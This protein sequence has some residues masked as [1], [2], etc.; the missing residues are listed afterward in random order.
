MSAEEASERAVCFRG[1]TLSLGVSSE[2]E[3]RKERMGLSGFDVET[4]S[5]IDFDC[6]SDDF[7]ETMSPSFFSVVSS[8]CGN[9]ASDSFSSV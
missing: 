1:G 3:E 5:V 8:L 9:G 2:N 4:S 6:I 7:E